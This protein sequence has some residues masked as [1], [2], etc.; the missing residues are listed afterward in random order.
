[1]AMGQSLWIDKG[2]VLTRSFANYR[3]V[4]TLRLKNFDIENYGST[5]V[6]AQVLMQLSNGLVVASDVVSYSMQDAVEMIDAHLTD[7][8]DTQI[9]AVKEMLEGLVAPNNW[10]IPNLKA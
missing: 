10:N 6:N 1:M 8:T 5:K 2:V 4:L 9:I 7:Y 3:E